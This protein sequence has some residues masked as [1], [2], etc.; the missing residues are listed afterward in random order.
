[1]QL[2]YENSH[3]KYP[4]MLQQAL[5]K[6]GISYS[7]IVQGNDG[8]LIVNGVDEGNQDAVN[9]IVSNLLAWQN[10]QTFNSV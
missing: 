6:D 10:S 8:L 7:G 5:D 3:I 1:M 9:L 4:V 2:V